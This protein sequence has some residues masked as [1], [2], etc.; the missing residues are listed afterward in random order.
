MILCTKT[1]SIHHIDA[2]FFLSVL[3]LIIKS[4]HNIVEVLW[5]HEHEPRVN[6]STRK[7]DNVTAELASICF[8]L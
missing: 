6:E 4:H 5:I 1:S 3:L 7:F 2:S 8:L